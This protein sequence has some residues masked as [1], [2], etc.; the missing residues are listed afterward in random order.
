MRTLSDF[1][2]YWTLVEITNVCNMHCKF[3]PSDSIHRP[4]RFM[5][6]N[7]FKKT[8]DQL[9]MLSPSRPILLHSLGEPLLHKDIFRFIDYSAS[10]NIKICLYTNGVTL[11]EN[12]SEVCK[13][14]NIETMVISVQTPTAETY[15]MR[16]SAKPFDN[17]MEDIYKA[18]NY[19]IESNSK[20]EVE[21]YLAETKS[22]PFRHW[23]ILTDPIEAL[24]I[25]K[26]MC[27][28]IPHTNQ[29]FNDIPID[30]INELYPCYKI[31]ID[32]HVI[33]IR[34]KH[35]RTW[36]NLFP[37]NASKDTIEKNLR[38]TCDQAKS[39]L[40]I[41]ADGTIS[42]CCLDIEG[43]LD[44]GNIRDIAILD[45]LMSNKRKKIISDVKEAEV[46]RRCLGI[47]HLKI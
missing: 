32:G 44:L 38:T 47:E 43:E 2:V 18:L 9:A 12:I 8:I 40:V 19:F 22:L 5:D 28:R 33:Y 36:G 21:I 1:G 3:C 34:I 31:I 25:I 16:G 14:V 24:H 6:F 46:C 7:L 13:R 4:R 11:L 42:I 35:F 10:K 39:D 15:K 41:L 27:R 30:F 45:A 37:I 23:D 20:M 26:E 29:S 17:Y